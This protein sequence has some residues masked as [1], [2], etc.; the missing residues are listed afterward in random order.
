MQNHSSK[1]WF[2][3]LALAAASLFVLGWWP[4]WAGSEPALSSEALGASAC[5]LI[6]LCLSRLAFL[7]VR[8]ARLEA[9]LHRARDAAESRRPQPLVGPPAL[10]HRL[11][12]LGIEEP[13]QTSSGSNG[14]HPGRGAPHAA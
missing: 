13:A 3:G 10:T 2:V 5:V 12:E 8:L 11:R 9:E 4:T 14:A 1:I 6:G 7:G